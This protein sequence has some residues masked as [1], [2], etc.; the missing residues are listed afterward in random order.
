[1]PTTI[2]AP[3]A[4]AAAPAASQPAAGNTTGHPASN[5]DLYGVSEEIDALDTA[6]SQAPADKSNAQKPPPKP[7]E[8]PEAKKPTDEEEIQALDESEDMPKKAK[9]DDKEPEL[10]KEQPAAEEEVTPTRAKDLKRVY[11]ETKAVKKQLETK[12][13][14]AEKR[15]EELQ[16]T[17]PDELKAVSDR[18]A[19]AEARRDELEQ[20]MRYLDY[21]ESSEFKDKYQT[22]INEAWQRAILDLNETVVTLEDGSTR[23]ATVDDLVHIGNMPL[24]DAARVA[25][26][27]F[28]DA[29]HDIMAHR[30]TI[31]ELTI[32]QDKA[33]ERAQKEAGE[34]RK[35]EEVESRQR[36]EKYQTLWKE[37]SEALATKYPK[38][39]K[40][41]EGDEDGNKLLNAGYQEVDRFFNDNTLAPEDR[42]KL[43]AKIRM[44]AAN[45]DRMALRLRR[46]AG[47]IQ[48]LKTKL[49]EFEQ[50][51]PPAGK[52]TPRGGR[53]GNGLI[54]D[55]LSE[56]EALNNPNLD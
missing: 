48:E 3:A 42:I 13:A 51:A 15:I 8:E 36:A 44:K 43:H 49:S 29:A 16:R 47:K 35:I 34:K 24:Q 21:R 55:A 45:H 5:D 46:M 41:V 28:G 40:P 12:L 20:K 14:D 56:I 17:N 6:T 32:Q 39:M 1:M 27:M 10:E 38:W 52:T 31:R 23:K 7:K 54:D 26:E 2:T 9:E 18:L 53:S 19:K 11:E 30:R 22:P 37:E 25:R 4:P 50:S 33:L